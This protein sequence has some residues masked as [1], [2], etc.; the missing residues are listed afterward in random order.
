M[1]ADKP[2]LKYT[3]GYDEKLHSQKDFQRT[4]KKGRRLVHPALLIY[5]GSGGDS[6]RRRRMGLITSRKLGT[7]VK[8]NRIKRRLREIFRL[9]KHSLKPGTDLIFQPKAPAMLLDYAQLETIVLSQL[10]KAGLTVE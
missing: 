8:R 5:T 7:A 3:F 10:K 6:S 1:E 4:L 2:D 9:N